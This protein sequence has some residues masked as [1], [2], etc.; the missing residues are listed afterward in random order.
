[1]LTD[2]VSVSVCIG[3]ANH[4][5][6]SAYLKSVVAPTPTT[7]TPRGLVPLGLAIFLLALGTNV[8]VTTLIAGR[9]WYLSPRKARKMGSVQFPTGIGRAI[10]DIVIESGMLYLA[11]QLIFVILFAIR[12]PALCIAEVIAVQIYVR[13]PHPWKAE[14]SL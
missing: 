11:V 4:L 14:N 12:R 3:V 13:I 9:I 10:I 6:L 7:P 1:M 5:L 2:H 8:I